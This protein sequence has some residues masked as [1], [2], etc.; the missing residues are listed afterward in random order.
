MGWLGSLSLNPLFGK[1]KPAQ[2]KRSRELQVRTCP[3]HTI[4]TPTPR[5][6]APGCVVVFKKQTTF[7]QSLSPSNQ[8]KKKTKNYFPDVCEHQSLPAA[9]PKTASCSTKHRENKSPGIDSNCEVL[10]GESI[11]STQA[12]RTVP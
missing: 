4:P 2:V 6:P 7:I 1:P 3:N 9:K 5:P 11:N 8:K 12:E 10:K